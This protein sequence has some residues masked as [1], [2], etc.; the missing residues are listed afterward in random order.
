M[1]TNNVCFQGG[2]SW[3]T[4]QEGQIG[5]GEENPVIYT[6]L[7]CEKKVKH[8]GSMS[9]IEV[10]RRREDVV[11]EKKSLEMSKGR[12]GNKRCPKEEPN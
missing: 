5:T 2:K 8:K 12:K 6:K 4:R 3:N 1:I 11:K 10:R 9:Q 7:G